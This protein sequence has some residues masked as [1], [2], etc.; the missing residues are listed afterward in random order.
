MLQLC[1]IHC[2]PMDCSCPGSFVHGVIPARILEWV[3][4]F[5]SRGS[6]KPGDQNPRL[7]HWQEDFFFLFLPLRYLGSW[8]ILFQSVS[9]VTQSV[10]LL[11]TL[12][13]E[14]RQAS[15]SITNSWSLLKLM[16]IESVTLSN[17]LIPFTFCLSSFPASR[18]FPVSQFFAPDGQSI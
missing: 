9:S 3:A 12:W 6:S 8:Y 16:S 18:S 1:P 13:T 10:Q 5:S 14:V 17:H 4:S 11:G 15:L 7:L 2:D